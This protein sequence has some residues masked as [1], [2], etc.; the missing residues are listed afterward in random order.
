MLSNLWFCDLATAHRIQAFLRTPAAELVNARLEAPAPTE[1]ERRGS[2]AI[3]PVRGVLAKEPSMLEQVFLGATDAERIAQSMLQAGEEA[4]TVVVDIHSGGGEE[5][6]VD[7]MREAFQ[8]LNAAG[9]RTVAFNTGARFSAALYGTLDAAEH[10]ATPMSRDGSIGAYLI[11]QDSSEADAK[12]GVKYELFASGPLKGADH[13]SQPVT[14]ESRAHFQQRADAGGAQFARAVAE[15]FNLANPETW[16]TGATFSAAEALELGLIQEIIPKRAL[17]SRLLEPKR[18][19]GRVLS[20][21]GANLAPRKEHMS[22]LQTLLA[23]VTEDNAPTLEQITTAHAADMKAAE[24][25]AV[26]LTAALGLESYDLDAAKALKAKADDGDKYRASLLEQ[27]K[28]LLVTI[29]G[30]DEGAARQ[31]RFMAVYANAPISALE[32]TVT[33]LT[34]DRDRLFP[35]AQQSVETD[36]DTKTHTSRASAATA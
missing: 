33:D 20:L 12:Q 13:P 1:T 15:R 29:H 26:K 25:K 6:A 9:V 14:D 35:N 18:A 7:T 11:K 22:Q 16:A 5:F 21:S 34:K 19:R 31:E 24:D 17:Y 28:H 2:V 23:S 4:E 32:G 10:Y 3:V 36:T 30:A 8:T 27:G